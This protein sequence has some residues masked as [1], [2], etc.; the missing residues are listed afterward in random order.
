M[1]AKTAKPKAAPKSPADQSEA[2]LKR[3]YVRQA[4]SL[5][6]LA[7]P[8]RLR[9]IVEGIQAGEDGFFVGETAV[10][11]KLTQPALSHHVTLLKAGRMIE[12]ER[13]GKTIRYRVVRE[14]LE[15]LRPLLA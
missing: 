6:L 14:A 1:S 11:L 13:I 12:G 8:I 10:R 15:P 2:D 9:L 7:D 5:K 3:E 4:E